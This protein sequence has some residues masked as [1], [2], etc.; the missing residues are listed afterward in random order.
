MMPTDDVNAQLAEARARLEALDRPLTPLHPDKVRDIRTI[1]AALDEQ[2]TRAERAEA[3]NV[4]WVLWKEHYDALLAE[5]E[6]LRRVVEAARRCNDAETGTRGG[7]CDVVADA[8]AALD[9]KEGVSMATTYPESVLTA[10][11][12]LLDAIYREARRAA[13]FEVSALSI[14][15]PIDE[16]PWLRDQRYGRDKYDAR[17]YAVMGA[18][19]H[20]VEGIAGAI[21]DEIAALFAVAYMAG[22][23]ARDDR[24]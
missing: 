16:T 14:D 10:K 3:D 19:D 22:M 1:L 20:F 11:W 21:E 18:K 2:T 4:R 15:R 7:S 6:R 8:L 5:N 13:D 23:E 12:R 9:A 24:A 17:W